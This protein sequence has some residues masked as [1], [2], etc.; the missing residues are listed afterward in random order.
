[1]SLRTC[2]VCGKQFEVA[3]P[4]NK[5]LCSRECIY[6]NLHRNSRIQQE[7]KRTQVVR[8]SCR[9]CGKEVISTAYCVQNFCGGKSGECRR[10]YLIR[11][12]QGKA[13]PAYRNGLR[14]GSRRSIYTSKHMRACAKYRKA[15]METHDWMF[16]ELCHANETM[17]PKFEV[18]HIYFASLYPKHPQL[19]NFKNLILLCLRCHNNMHAGN[20]NR[21]EF[22]N[23]ERNRKLKELFA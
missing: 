7:K 6:E 14:V 11:T 18:H 15:F 17:T 23:L 4:W 3:I 10:A 21:K 22:E 1:M 2:K 5:N 19:H 16:C 13:N 12:R 9:E 20:K 8:K